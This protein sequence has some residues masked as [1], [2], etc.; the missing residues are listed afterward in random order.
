ML[1]EPEAW[2]V[3]TTPYLSKDNGVRAIARNAVPM[4]IQLRKEKI[5]SEKKEFIQDKVGLTQNRF[6]AYMMLHERMSEADALSRYAYLTQAQALTT[7]KKVDEDG[8]P[9][10]WAK[11]SPKDLMFNFDSQLCALQC[12]RRCL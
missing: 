6:I 7:C 10:I 5:K 8:Q 4:E 2:R 12:R 9:I 1:N 11:E 3:K